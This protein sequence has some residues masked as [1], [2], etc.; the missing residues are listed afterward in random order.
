MGL[1]NPSINSCSNVFHR[2]SKGHVITFFFFCNSK[3]DEAWAFRWYLGYF[4]V[5]PILAANSFG[6]V[7]Q[8]EFSVTGGTHSRI[9]MD[10]NASARGIYHQKVHLVVIYSLHFF[11]KIG[12]SL[13]VLMVTLGCV[14]RGTVLVRH[15]DICLLTRQ[16]CRPWVFHF[17]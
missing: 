16:Q 7:N 10:V 11:Y 9:C 8:V 4:R 15:R 13:F 1:G 2:I 12:Q 6:A 14:N 3:C 5:W 17:L